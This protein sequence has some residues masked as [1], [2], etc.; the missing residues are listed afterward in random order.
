M[1]YQADVQEYGSNEAPEDILQS[2]AMRKLFVGG[3]SR[4][5]TEETFGSYFSQFGEVEDRVI[6][7][8][9]E[10]QQSRGFGFVTFKNSDTVEEVFKTKPHE[11]DGKTVDA[12]RAMPKDFNTPAAH[13]KTTRLFIGGFKGCAVEPEEV[14][15]YI[16][17]RHSASS[18][19]IVKIDFLKDKETGENKGFGFIDCSD[20]DFADRLVL[21][22]SSFT[23]KGR[24]MS[25]KKAE[26]R[27]GGDGN[28]FRGRGGGGF[29]GGRGRGG[30]RGG[31]RDRNNGGG[32]NQGGGY[33]SGGS[34]YNQGSGYNN[35]SG[36]GY[37]QGGG[38]GGY[39]QGSYGGGGGGNSYGGGNQNYGGYYNNQSSGGG[40]GGG[41][42]YN[43]GGGYQQQQQTGFDNNSYSQQQSGGYGGYQ[44][45]PGAGRGG[46]RGRGGNGG[47]S[48][49]R[50]NPY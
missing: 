6:I 15:E 34:G 45:G 42:G 14:S 28:N 36:G 26:P 21:C 44:G 25:I 37:Q 40:S 12:K 7:K 5:T 4:D 27:D 22:E 19:N 16:E 48:N 30:G 41:G 2:E 20:N 50:Y 49:S 33:N 13:A 9:G 11:L 32:Y 39:N 47:N 31:F 23:F 38:G 35:Q 10:T 43:S 1:S 18:G 3:L 46:G 17:S 29:R 24:T 8:D